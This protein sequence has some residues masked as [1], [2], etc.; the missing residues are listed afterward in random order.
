M[1]HVDHR[2][3]EQLLQPA[4]LAAHLDPQLGVEIG[5]RFVEQQHMRLDHEGAG[6][7]DALELAAGQLVR[8]ALAVAVELHE[9]Q[10]ARDALA[11]PARAQ[12]CARCRP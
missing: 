11:D 7:R 8:P 3:A 10:R 9:L 5:E 12:L 1:R 4:D 6:D 2:D